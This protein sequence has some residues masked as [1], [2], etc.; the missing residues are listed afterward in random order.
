[1]QWNTPIK[2]HISIKLNLKQ[3]NKTLV[4]TNYDFGQI[5]LVDEIQTHQQTQILQQL[6]QILQVIFSTLQAIIVQNCIIATQTLHDKDY[7]QNI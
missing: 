2:L 4:K 6:Q 1:M 7:H 5:M 3:Q